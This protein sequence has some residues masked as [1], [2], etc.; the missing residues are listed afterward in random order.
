MYQAA[1][2]VLV[3]AVNGYRP[4]FGKGFLAYAIPTMRGEVKR[5]FRDF[6]WSVGVARSDQE[7]FLATLRRRDAMTQELG[8]E[9][10]NEELAG[11]MGTTAA[12]VQATLALSN[13]QRPAS[14]DRPMGADDESGN[15]YD[16]EGS[17][18]RRLALVDDIV[19][20]SRAIPHLDDRDRR[21]LKMRFWDDLTQAQVAERLDLSQM[22]VSRLL[23]RT[24]ASL[25]QAMHTA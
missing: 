22:H 10:T 5:F 2:L 7:L 4:E 9:A 16:V 17:E 23:T 15:H 21:I 19:S 24:F 18:D 8:R 20:L 14:L 25:R 1:A 6:V 3:K 13:A 11:E 12:H